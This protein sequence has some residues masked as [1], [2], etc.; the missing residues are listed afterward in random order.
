MECCNK[1]GWDKTT[2]LWQIFTINSM[3]LSCDKWGWDKLIS[4]GSCWT[5]AAA[6]SASFKACS[7]WDN[8][9]SSSFEVDGATY[10]FGL[11]G[12]PIFL[13]LLMLWLVWPHLPHV[14]SANFL[15][16]LC[17]VTLSSSTDLL[18]F[19]FGLPLW[20]FLCGGT[21]CAYCVWAQYYGPWTGWIKW[22]YV[23]L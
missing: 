3:S 8:R 9:W 10:F 18:L 14:N 15:F 21:G 12:T 5:W 19:F 20:T 17:P 23:L 11:T 22:W 7:S 2:L 1:L 13:Q 16:S 4:T 6:S